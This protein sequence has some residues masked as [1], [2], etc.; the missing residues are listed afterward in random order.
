[1]RRISLLGVVAALPLGLGL[2]GCAGADTDPDDLR[3]DLSEELQ[4]DG[5]GLPADEADCFAGILIDE[6]GV[7]ELEDVDFNDEEPPEE[8]R[9]QIAEAATIAIDECDIDSATLG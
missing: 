2:P 4:A 8:L 6:I 5:D 7:E 1:M 9:A 3:A